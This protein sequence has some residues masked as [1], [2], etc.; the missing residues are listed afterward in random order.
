[1]GHTK[2]C[3]VRIEE[4]LKSDETYQERLLEAESRKTRFLAEE[5]EQ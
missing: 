4:L 3:R 5:L 1:M 2:D